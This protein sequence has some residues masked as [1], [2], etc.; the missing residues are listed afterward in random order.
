MYIRSS[1]SPWSLRMRRW[2]ASPLSPSAWETLCSRIPL[3]PWARLLNQYQGGMCIFGGI[4]DDRKD[5]T[6]LHI[7][8]SRLMKKRSA[9]GRSPFAGSLRVSLRYKFIPLPGQE[10]GQGMVERVFQHPVR[11]Q[12]SEHR[13]CG[14]SIC[15]FRLGFSLE[16]RTGGSL[17]L[18]LDSQEQRALEGITIPATIQRWYCL[19][20]SQAHLTGQNQEP[21]C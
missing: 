19:P 4:D 18:F 7:T 11:P 9:E 17:V 6:A 12:L 14:L 5:A 13:Q 20:S 15:T 1:R 16:A 10:G 21:L 3:G 8:F 2:V